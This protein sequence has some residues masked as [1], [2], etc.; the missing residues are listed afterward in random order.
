M[1]RLVSLVTFFLSGHINGFCLAVP[2]SQRSSTLPA[3]SQVSGGVVRG[4]QRFLQMLPGVFVR[5]ADLTKTVGSIVTL[6]ESKKSDHFIHRG[7]LQ[8]TIK[9]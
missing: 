4:V 8:I 7:Q 2:L 3:C 5:T 1:G 9:C 6:R